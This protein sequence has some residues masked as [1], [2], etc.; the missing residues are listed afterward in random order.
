MVKQVTGQEMLG[1]GWGGAGKRKRQKEIQ[2]QRQCNRD[3]D[4]DGEEQR[5]ANQRRKNRDGEKKTE[6]ETGPLRDTQTDSDPEGGDPGAP[7]FRGKVPPSPPN[8]PSRSAPLGRTRLSCAALAACA[9]SRA[10]LVHCCHSHTA[11]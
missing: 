3:R 1:R 7:P 5:E 11:H 6:K 9:G 4:K 2:S 8:L 10:S